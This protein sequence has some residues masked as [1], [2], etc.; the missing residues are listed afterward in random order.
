MGAIKCTVAGRSLTIANQT[1][2]TLPGSALSTGAVYSL[3]TGVM[4]GADVNLITGAPVVFFMKGDA[5]VGDV[6]AEGAGISVVCDRA[7]RVVTVGSASELVRVDVFDAAG[8]VVAGGNAG[9]DRAEVSL[10]GCGAGIYVVRAVD[11]AGHS[12]TVKVAL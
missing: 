11:R 2:A 7:R 1:D 12:A 3:A 4:A 9:G 10:A 5:G 8:R 6:E